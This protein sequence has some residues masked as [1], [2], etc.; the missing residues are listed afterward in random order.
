MLSQ[1]LVSV[2]VSPP[3]RCFASVQPQV[4]CRR[5]RLSYPDMSH[6]LAGCSDESGRCSSG[7]A[8]RC[9]ARALRDLHISLQTSKDQDV[10]PSRVTPVEVIRLLPDQDLMPQFTFGSQQDAQ[11]SGAILLLYML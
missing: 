3:S 11:V 8:S 2:F 6:L 9:L 1:Q 10:T 4:H 5:R 7:V